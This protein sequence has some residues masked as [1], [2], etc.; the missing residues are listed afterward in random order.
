MAALIA[1]GEVLARWPEYRSA[2]ERAVEVYRAAYLEAYDT[3]RS[4]AEGIEAA[5]RTGAAYLGA[6]A[7]RREA[8]MAEVFGA[9]RPCHYLPLTLP[10]VRSLLEAAG[11]KSLSSLAESVVALPGYRAQVEGALRELSA[12][13][14]RRARRFMSGILRLFWVGASVRS[15]K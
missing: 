10:T 5:L 15:P 9:G 12:P 3:I 6:P 7:D 1:N 4:A 11:R 13:L 8:V 2:F 14:Q